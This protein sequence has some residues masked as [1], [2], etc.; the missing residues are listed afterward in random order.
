MAQGPRDRDSVGDDLDVID[1]LAVRTSC[2]RNGTTSSK[3]TFPE[4]SS[5]TTS[6]VRCG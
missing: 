6:R 5:T 1:P 4:V 2:P 3:R